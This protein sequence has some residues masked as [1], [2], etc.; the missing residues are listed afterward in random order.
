[1]VVVTKKQRASCK[2]PKNDTQMHTLPD[3][4]IM[5]SAKD[6]IL[7]KCADGDEEGVREE[8]A[9]MDLS[10]IVDKHRSTAVH[11]AA[12]GGSLGVIKILVNEYG[13]DVLLDINKDGRNALHWAARNGQILV[14]EYLLQ[15][16]ADIDQ[17][18]KT[19]NTALHWAIWG[20]QLPACK[21]LISQGADIHIENATQCT[22]IHWA[23]A[24]GSITVCEYLHSI[25]SDFT[26]INSAGHG[27][28]TKAAWEGHTE[29][30]LWFLTELG[31][32]E[33]LKLKDIHGC[34]TSQLARKNG[35]V[36]LADMLEK[37]Y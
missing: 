18:T 31:L 2:K 23:A 15:M 1:M 22:A 27:A 14:M 13:E 10:K 30:V 3:G 17:P 4:K 16:G 32:S 28:V 21:W 19:G 35:H 9:T 37:N 26:I 11:W 33:Q 12:G 20:S 29:L 34:T 6:G 24:R 5:V 8:L 7:K 25:G 36:D